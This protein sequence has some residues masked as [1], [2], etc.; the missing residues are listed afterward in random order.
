MV[1]HFDDVKVL[2][3]DVLLNDPDFWLLSACIVDAAV[4]AQL[5]TDS[6]LDLFLISLFW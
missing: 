6:T 3:E 1:E 5:P 2:D 4:S